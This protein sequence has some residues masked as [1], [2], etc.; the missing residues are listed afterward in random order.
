ME[1]RTRAEL[2]RYLDGG[3]SL[4]EAT[5]FLDAVRRD[6]EAL[7]SL[8]RALQDQAHLYDVL[9]ER[10]APATRRTAKA[11]RYRAGGAGSP[12]GAFPWLAGLVAAGV[13]ILL[14]LS[15]SVAPLRTRPAPPLAREPQAADPAPNPSP[16]P[17]PA[18]KP[19]APLP[20]RPPETPTPQRAPAPPT[21]ESPR[22]TPD[23]APAP[24]PGPPPPSPKPPEKKT[25]TTLAQIEQAQGDVTLVEG[26]AERPARAG[27]GLTVGARLRTGSPGSASFRFPDGTRIELSAAAAVEMAP[28]DKGK[29]VVLTGGALAADVKPQPAGMP[30]VV[31]TRHAEVVVV[32][33]RFSVALTADG[34]RL[35]VREGKVRFHRT[36]DRASVE[37]RAGQFATAAPAIEPVARPL[38][39][40]DVLILPTQG[41]AI[42]GDWRLVRDGAA[43]S[44]IALESLKTSNKLPGL[45]KED[46]RLAF[47]VHADADR[48]YFVWVRGCTLAEKQIARDA[49]VLDFGANAIVAERPGPNQ[50][51][52][53]GTPRGLFNGFMHRQGYWWIGGDADD[54]NDE[55]PVLVRFFK[56]GEQ[57]VLLYAYES[58]V[59][60]DAIW[61]S[62]TQKTRPAPTTSG[63]A[64]R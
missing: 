23:P 58:P 2:E 22:S 53:G 38:P 4:P 55:E 20:S 6:P 44:G 42:G 3:M 21:V 5:A 31:A 18:E 10:P 59:R 62:T 12:P 63:P 17:P 48:D 32:G 41:I 64:P 16:P 50:G 14:V 51:K 56:P 60:I 27:D 61:L 11:R 15:A 9:R 1:E 43:G 46:P 40:D 45:K 37:V 26:D 35:E 52:A 19:P 57:T 24:A 28:P 33:T 47:R 36:G 7:A 8:G 34:T 25:V 39:I 30:M 13:L 49:V 54:K 29:L